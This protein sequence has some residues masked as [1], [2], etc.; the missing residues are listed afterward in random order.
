MT[1]TAFPRPNTVDP[2]EA[3]GR[4]V[5]GAAFALLDQIGDLQPVRLVDLAAATGIPRPTVHRLLKQ[6]IEVGAV[7]RDRARYRLGA[8]LLGLGAQ[9]TP[10]RKLRAVARRPLAELAATTGAATSLTAMLG[11]AAVFLDTIDARV[12]LGFR[13]EPGSPVP[14]GTAQAL[15]HHSAGRLTPVIDAG[16]VQPGVSCVAVTITLGG[17]AVAAVTTV[18]AGMR[19]SPAMLTATRATAARI[20]G[21]LDVAQTP[22]ADGKSPLTEP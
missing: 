12:P 18:I 8:S 17:G 2:A 16:G 6:L 11:G 10:E 9:V 13:A 7:R 4:G 19:P 5:V 22:W 1:V 3:S 15:A 14:P 20:A 21:R